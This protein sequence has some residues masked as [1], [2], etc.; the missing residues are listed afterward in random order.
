MDVHP[1]HG[2]PTHCPNGHALSYPNVKVGWVRCDCAGGDGHQ[3]WLCLDCGHESVAQP[4]EEGR[5]AR[6]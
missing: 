3:T 4:H 5:E 2:G 1:V 6:F